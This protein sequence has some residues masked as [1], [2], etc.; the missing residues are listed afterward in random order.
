VSKESGKGKV[1]EFDLNRK[2]K[3]KPTNYIDP[4]KKQFKTAR[5]KENNITVVKYKSLKYTALFVLL[6]M[7][8]YILKM[9]F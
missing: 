1:L 2:K 3:L 6:C 9:S 4:A 5:A 7:I 8:V